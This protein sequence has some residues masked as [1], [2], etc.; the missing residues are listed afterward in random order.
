M[1]R[2]TVSGML[3]APIGFA[4][5]LFAGPPAAVAI[6]LQK[7]D[8]LD[9]KISIGRILCASPFIMAAPFFG[10][11]YGPIRGAVI[12]TG[13][14]KQGT[15]AARELFIPHSKFKSTYPDPQKDCNTMDEDFRKEK[16][17]GNTFFKSPKKHFEYIE[18]NVDT[19]DYRF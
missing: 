12:G 17:Y 2:Q 10:A 9:H 13:G 14:I 8:L 3:G 19:Q 16:K 5:G 6:V 7:A 18:T 15:L 1:F 4:E 11:V